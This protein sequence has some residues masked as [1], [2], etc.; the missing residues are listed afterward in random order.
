MKYPRYGYLDPGVDTVEAQSF[1]SPEKFKLPKFE[2]PISAVENLKRAARHDRPRWMPL[3]VTDIQSVAP[4]DCIL[5]TEKTAGLTVAADFTR[6]A[7]EDWTFRDWFLTDWTF[8]VSAGGP[9]LTPGAQVLDDVTKWESVVEFPNLDD[10]DFDTYASNYMKN[11]YDPQKALNIDIGLGCTE[12]F[13]SLMGGY[14]DAMMAFATEPGACRAFFERFIDH[15]IEQFD[16]LLEYYPI[17]MLTYHDDWGNEKDTFFSPKMLEDMLAEPTKRFI[18]HVK[19]RDIVFEFHSCGNIT[20]FIPYFI[21]FGVDFLQIQR[22]VVDYP[23]VK[24]QYGG[25]IGFCG[26]IEGLDFS[27]APP[28]KDEIIKLVRNTADVLGAG[29][30]YYGGPFFADP[31]A[32]WTAACEWYAYSREMYDRE[33]G[34]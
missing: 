18:R 6:F 30:G 10:W 11:V 32:L 19:S 15:E 17:T 29:G 1:F 3:S 31:E 2:R 14:T 33:R 9:M 24:E 8:V 5:P 25:K 27:S 7:K 13:V 20:R 12:R 26:G 23:A 16:R 22:R 21:D 34:E 4:N 28:E